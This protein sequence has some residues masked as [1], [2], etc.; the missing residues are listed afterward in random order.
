M[1]TYLYDEESR[2]EENTPPPKFV[3]IWAKTFTYDF[4][5]EDGRKIE[6]EDAYKDA[7]ALEEELNQEIEVQNQIEKECE[8]IHAI[9]RIIESRIAYNKYL[10]DFMKNKP[11]EN[12][13]A[14]IKE[15]YR[16]TLPLQKSGAVAKGLIIGA[17]RDIEAYQ[18]LKE[19]VETDVSNPLLLE[20]LYDQI[21]I[22]FRQE[23]KET[24]AA[25]R[26]NPAF[27]F[28]SQ[29]A[30]MEILKPF[31][32][33]LHASYEAYMLKE[34]PSWNY[35]FERLDSFY[36]KT[37]TKLTHALNTY[38][39][40][41]DSP[42]ELTDMSNDID[43]YATNKLTQISKN[44]N[45]RHASC[46][47]EI[48]NSTKATSP[49]E[50]AP[51]GFQKTF[52]YNKFF[53]ETFYELHS[54]SELLDKC[55]S[56]LDELVQAKHKI[57]TKKQK[58]TNAVPMGNNLELP[59]EAPVVIPEAVLL[60]QNI[61]NNEADSKKQVFLEFLAQKQEELRLYKERVEAARQA[62]FDVTAER[63]RLLREASN[64]PEVETKEL[65]EH[66]VLQLCY[67]AKN[68]K[69][70]RNT[71]EA[72]FQGTPVGFDDLNHMI[73]A[74]SPKTLIDPAQYQAFSL[75]DFHGSSHFAASIPNTHKIWAKVRNN[76]AD[77]YYIE[78]SK[79]STINSWRPHGTAHNKEI[80]SHRAAKKCVMGLTLAGITPERIEEALSLKSEARAKAKP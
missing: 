51:I 58:K 46:I 3:D 9:S 62:K 34:N 47:I 17:A 53:K 32:S 38:I 52:E 43:S 12:M 19:Y 78:P 68:L 36:K 49:F 27:E 39:L 73:L 29:K 69:H 26:D 55:Q 50:P 74:L 33:P 4:T 71:L 45:E 30:M 57:K 66:E 31:L 35:F 1:L 18:R 22:L 37:K 10:I 14:Y 25:Q 42:G 59:N 48:N 63:A 70:H 13:Q 41:Q 64:E 24:L 21:L 65:Q 56:G 77:P 76:D 5:K 60:E 23:Q 7:L 20:C 67:V 8:A 40:L 72:I 6:A 16:R 2:N 28:M 80:L 44:I 75:I 54:L 15:N 79:M 61:A 11:A